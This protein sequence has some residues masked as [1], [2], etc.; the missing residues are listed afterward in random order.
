M[1]S[2]LIGEKIEWYQEWPL[3]NVELLWPNSMGFLNEVLV[4][5]RI[6]ATLS[7]FVHWMNR[8]PLELDTQLRPT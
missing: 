6:T 8:V 2:D 1:S 3:V 7:G 4:T 5:G